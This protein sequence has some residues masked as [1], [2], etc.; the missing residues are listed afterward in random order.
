MKVGNPTKISCWSI[1]TATVVLLLVLDLRAFGLVAITGS[2]NRIWG[3]YEKTLLAL[4]AFLLFVFMDIEAKRDITSSRF[5]DRYVLGAVLSTV[6]LY[7][8]SV[9]EYPLQN[10]T[11][12]FLGGTHFFLVLL[13]LPLYGL[14][15]KQGGTE[16]IFAWMNR[17]TFLWYCILIIQSLAYMKSGRLFLHIDENIRNENIRISLN[18]I[19][20]LML[21]YNFD[22]FYSGRVKKKGFPVIQLALGAYCLIMVQQT[23]AYNVIIC[24]CIA[25]IV[26]LHTNTPVKTLR[27]LILIAAGII[28]LSQAGII[29]ILRKSLSVDNQ[30]YG[31]GTRARLLAIT[32]YWKAFLKS[33]LFGQGFINSKAYLNILR[34][35][36]GIYNYSD[37]GLLGLLAN[38]GL[39]CVILFVW[40][41]IRWGKQVLGY[42]SRQSSRAGNSFLIAF[43]IYIAGTSL[44]LIMADPQRILLLPLSLAVFEYARSKPS[45]C[46]GSN[47]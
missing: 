3:P 21:V 30:T 17:V 37:V 29:D 23:R 47:N 5:L 35:N 19:G 2:L 44:T 18:S 40:P 34:G 32:Y 6:F 25:A 10:L 42:L 28:V 1:V 26:M 27:S 38:T 7:F 36:K 22:L 41:L 46:T 14:L 24:I 8:Y 4:I 45:V 9:L 13:A 33:P 39:F 20:N 16:R 43:F 31:N 11:Q 15:R 12:T